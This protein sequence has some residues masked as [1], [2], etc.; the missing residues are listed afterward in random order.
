MRSLTKCFKK[1]KKNWRY[2]LQAIKMKVLEEKGQ[3]RG[4]GRGRKR[5]RRRRKR[6]R[7]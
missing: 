7:R 3:K 1:E 5:R 6:E 4:D 2:I